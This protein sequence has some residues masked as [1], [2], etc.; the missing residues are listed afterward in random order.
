MT[1][2]RIPDENL[3]K[4]TDAVAKVAKAARKLGLAE[5]KKEA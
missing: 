5:P 2:Y 4:L 1:T 3:L